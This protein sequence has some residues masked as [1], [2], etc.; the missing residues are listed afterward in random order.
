M[1]VIFPYCLL[2]VLASKNVHSLMICFMFLFFHSKQKD[3]TSMIDPISI[4][5]LICDHA[6]TKSLHTPMLSHKDNRQRT[7]MHY[8]ALRGASISCLHMLKVQITVLS[9]T[10][11]QYLHDSHDSRWYQCVN[12]IS[13][14]I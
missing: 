7:V 12:M 8:A 2:K 13:L 11:Y 6:V 10:F 9:F 5:R 3:E 14:H 1:I 4:V